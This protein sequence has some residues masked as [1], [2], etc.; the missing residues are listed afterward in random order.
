M[1]TNLPQQKV[2]EKSHFTIQSSDRVRPDVAIVHTD[3]DEE[4]ENKKDHVWAEISPKGRFARS[5][6]ELGRGAYKIVYKGIDNQT[7]NEVAWNTV[8]LSK[9]P[10]AD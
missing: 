6:E 1:E 5:N 7:G 2:E 8:Q 4:T 10:K 9:L 3:S